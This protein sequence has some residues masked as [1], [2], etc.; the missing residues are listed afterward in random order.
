MVIGVLLQIPARTNDLAV[1]EWI[2]T[3]HGAEVW[4][5]A[6]RD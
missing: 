2:V 6:A 1:R 5:L 3:Q 4:R